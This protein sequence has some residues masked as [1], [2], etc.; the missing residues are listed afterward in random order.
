MGLDKHQSRLKKGSTQSEKNRDIR[1]GPVTWNPQQR[2]TWDRASSVVSCRKGCRESAK[3]PKPD[4][5]PPSEIVMKC[6]AQIGPKS[7]ELMYASG[8]P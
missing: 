6:R 1:A 7:D 3:V 4:T 5:R 8:G 2:R